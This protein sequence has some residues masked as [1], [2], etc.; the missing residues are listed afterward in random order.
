MKLIVAFSL[1]ISFTLIPATIWAAPE[2]DNSGVAVLQK[3]SVME[4]NMYLSQMDPAEMAATLKLFRAMLVVKAQYVGNTTGS[5][6]M[7]GATKG[8]VNSLGDPYSVYMDPGMYKELMLETKGSFGGVGIV[9]GAKDKMLTV[10][11]PIEGTPAEAAGILSGD[12]ILRIDDLDTKEM[13]LDEAVGKIRGKEG[14]EVTLLIQR[15]GEEAKEYKLTRAIIL[16]KS[17]SGKMLVGKINQRQRLRAKTAGTEILWNA[18]SYSRSAQQ[19]RRPDRG[20]RQSGGTIGSQ[21]ADRVSH[22]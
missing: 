13:P 10:V 15:T 9:L 14:T 17:V 4:I 12:R 21:R 2:K 6:L 11:A 3:S 8:M 19:S 5:K 7:N 20:K 1:L 22:R 16:L 18:V